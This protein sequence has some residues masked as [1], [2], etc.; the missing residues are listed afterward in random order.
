MLGF[1]IGEG[2]RVKEGKGKGG[3]MLGVSVFEIWVFYLLLGV[4]NP[5]GGMGG[6]WDLK[7]EER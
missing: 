1:W 3:D 6:E 4:C 5:W 7:W 2:G